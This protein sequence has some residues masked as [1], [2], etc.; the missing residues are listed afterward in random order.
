[1]VDPLNVKQALRALVANTPRE[2]APV[3]EPE[4]DPIKRLGNKIQTDIIK[5]TPPGLLERAGSTAASGLSA[6]G[7]LLDVPGSMARDVLTWLPGGPKPANPFD[8]LLSPFSEKNRTTGRDLNRSYGLSG[9]EDTMLNFTGGMA[10]EILTDPLTYLT[11]GA[12]ALTKGGKA[13]KALGLMDKAPEVASRALGR[14]VGKREARHIV[15][16]RM[17]LSDPQLGKANIRSA[18]ENRMRNDFGLSE[19][20]MDR[21]LGG[22][23]KINLPF[24]DRPFRFGNKSFNW[25]GL[26]DEDGVIG[27]G[28]I[29][30]RGR[31][32]PSPEIEVPP[33]RDDGGDSWSRL[34]DDPNPPPLTDRDAPLPKSPVKS[35]EPI[36]P[37]DAGPEVSPLP[38]APKPDFDYSES[39]LESVKSFGYSDIEDIPRSYKEEAKKIG[40]NPVRLLAIESAVDNL[41]DMVSKEG[42]PQLHAWDKLQSDVNVRLDGLGLKDANAG[43]IDYAKKWLS[44]IDRPTTL[45]DLIEYGKS[46]VSRVPKNKQQSEAER[47][48]KKFGSI[49]DDEGAYYRSV[50]GQ[51]PKAKQQ[52]NL[53]DETDGTATNAPGVT[54]SSEIPQVKLNEPFI[55]DDRVMVITDVNGVK[56]PYYLSTGEGG[57][58]SVATGKWYPFFGVGKDKWI[59]KGSEKNI[60]EFYGSPSLKA[61]A[62]ELNNSLGSKYKASQKDLP[63][64]F[65]S[66]TKVSGDR[67]YVTANVNEG[68]SPVNWQDTVDNRQLHDANISNAIARIEGKASTA[69]IAETKP[70]QTVT[71]TTTTSADD[72]ALTNKKP[73]SEKLPSQEV[74]FREDPELFQRWKNGE[75]EELSRYTNNSEHDSIYFRWVDAGLE[76]PWPSLV[77]GDEKVWDEFRYAPQNVAPDISWDSVTP[78]KKAKELGGEKARTYKSLGDGIHESSDRRVVITKVASNRWDLA[79]DGRSVDEYASLKAAKNQAEFHINKPQSEG[80]LDFSSIDEV[81][82]KT[83]QENSKVEKPVLVSDRAKTLL[84]EAAGRVDESVAPKVDPEQIKKVQRWTRLIE[85]L[86][87]GKTQLNKYSAKDVDLARK[88]G[89]GEIEAAII[90]ERRLRQANAAPNTTI[91]NLVNSAVKNKVLPESAIAEANDISRRI[92]I[93][94]NLPKLN[95]QTANTAAQAERAA[96]AEIF[97]ELSDADK[98]LFSGPKEFG[99]QYS[100]LYQSEVLAKQ[101]QSSV[102]QGDALKPQGAPIDDARVIDL[103]TLEG[104]PEEAKPIVSAMVSKIGTKLFDDVQ[105]RLGG[106]APKPT[107]VGDIDMQRGFIN[108]YN[109]AITNGVVDRTT[110]HELWHHMSKYVSP[111][112]VRGVRNEFEAAVDKFKKANPKEK[113]PYDL[114]SVDEYFASKLTDLSMKYLGREKPVDLIGKTWAKAVE[115]F[116]YVWDAIRQTLGYDRTKKIMQGFLAGKL[117]GATKVSDLSMAQRLADELAPSDVLESAYRSQVETPAFKNWFGDWEKDPKNASKVVDAEGKPLVVY[118]G[119]DQVFTEFTQAGKRDLGYLG[120]GFYFTG[121]ANTAEMYSGAINTPPSLGAN[122]MPVFLSITNPL[123]IKGGRSRLYDMYPG[124][125]GEALTAA[126]RKD[127]YDGVV[128]QSNSGLTEYVAFEPEQIKSATGNRG[129]FDPA[130][131]NILESEADPL[132]S[133]KEVADQLSEFRSAKIGK[134]LDYAAETVLDSAVGR[135]IQALFDQSVLGQLSKA[136]QDAAR[137]AFTGYRDAIH[138]ERTFMSKFIRPWYETPNIREDEI[139]ANE[140]KPLDEYISKANGNKREASLMQLADARRIQNSRIND[141]RRLLERTAKDNEG[142]VSPALITV[143]PD[144]LPTWV[145]QEIVNGKPVANPARRAQLANLITSFRFKAMNMIRDENAN[146]IATRAIDGYSPRVLSVMPK[147]PLINWNP[148]YGK[149]LDPTHPNQKRR[150]AYLS[151]YDDNTAVVNDI[152]VDP[153]FSGIHSKKK[154]R[155]EPTESEIKQVAR[156]LWSKYGNRLNAGYANRTYDQLIQIDVDFAKKISDLSEEMMKLNPDHVK[157]QIPLFSN[158]LFSA[159]ELRLEHHYRSIAHAKAIQYLLGNNTTVGRLLKGD[160]DG[161]VLGDVLKNTKYAN[162]DAIQKVLQKIPNSTKLEADKEFWDTKIQKRIKLI[163]DAFNTAIDPDPAKRKKLVDINGGPVKWNPSESKATYAN[164]IPV[165]DNNKQFDLE[166]IFDT[167]NPDLSQARIIENVRDGEDWQVIAYDIPN[168]TNV[169]PESYRSS[170]PKE[171]MLQNLVVPQDVADAV[172]KFVRGP[173]PLDE[174]KPLIRTYDKMTNMWKMMQTGMLPF[175]SFHTRN[176]GSGLASNLYMGIQSDPRFADFNLADPKTYLNPLRSVA[177]PV[178][179][180]HL[181]STGQTVPGISKAPIF[182]GKNLTDEQATEELRKIIYANAIVGEKQGISAEQLMDTV[183]TAASQYPGIDGARS[184]NPL[185]GRFSQPVPESTFAQRWFMPWMSKGV[186]SEKDIFRPGQLGRDLGQYTES[187]NRLSPFIAMIR[188][189]YDPRAAAAMVNKAQVDYTMLSNFEREYMRRLFPFYSFTRG[190]T[191]TVYGQLLER[192]GGAMGRTIMATTQAG[193]GAEQGV[194]PDYIRETASIPLGMSGDGTRSY[195]TGFGLPFEDPLQFAQIARG[196]VSG[197]LRELGSRLNPVPKSVIEVGTGRSLYQAGPFGGREI[198]DLDPTIGRIRANINDLITGQ[199]TERAEPFLDNPWAEYLIANSGLGRSLNTIRTATDPRKYDTIPWK[200]L[201]NLGTGVRV[202]DVS[203]SAQDAI[204]RER[205]ARVMKD[206]GGRMYSRPYFPDWA[207]EKWT[208]EQAADAAQIEAIMKLL[209]DRASERKRMEQAQ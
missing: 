16:P 108:I 208:P 101:K 160:S 23:A 104:L 95:P 182:A 8:Q 164:I 120:K 37:V 43:E 12:S 88:V 148:N 129:T 94:E 33:P 48:F 14:K 46:Q 29:R 59:N 98:S 19:A 36:K 77:K 187:L 135:S 109:T 121:S 93:S 138:R 161:V 107:T 190:M 83:K 9:K 159:F 89:F 52:K 58:K 11:F 130:S 45:N 114:S 171:V 141:L 67:R 198:E 78:F 96:T 99:S 172:T 91:L 140:L 47:I 1:M 71:D 53:I 166:I 27:A 180:A 163:E 13:A 62:D 189:G 76:H 73:K 137:L 57:K 103:K 24:S 110:V 39:E 142:R 22:M 35:P 165:K 40:S 133:S 31:P 105:V 72:F 51:V 92:V 181:I 153:E 126:I 5:E 34:P 84:D 17:I 32:L 85:D 125:S 131:K 145:G 207:E 150:A 63:V 20:D 184:I 177:Q 152:S 7:N 82:S 149:L 209:N 194:T 79:I 157:Y 201:L 74:L 167:S 183:G 205:L 188:Q 179:D 87:V 154:V 195:I 158:D 90:E 186:M 200:L 173:K 112:E 199:K 2:P 139:I 175:L 122:I 42:Y 136:G 15:T 119:T 170:T 151:G 147:D 132:L 38:E 66:T 123:I 61:K 144:Q 30:G 146:G 28:K 143:T 204:L 116:E 65:G 69:S 124:K 128:H 56:V 134:G 97:G 60:N 174:V 168:P 21:Q 4:R 117:S 156:Q 70:T 80:L 185:R 193:Q 44:T 111:E 49:D 113:L 202:A 106:N 206:F 100:K 176:L 178:R 3:S 169:N 18:L 41:I 115:V 54:A 6:V 26:T 102:M 162:D 55:H 197:L 86:K 155:Q 68:F 64:A 10:T 25:F 203:P 192:P 127:G 118:H 81:G 191:P 50:L 75:V 196:N